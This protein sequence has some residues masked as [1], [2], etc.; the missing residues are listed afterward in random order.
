MRTELT[1]F[2]KE[3]EREILAFI[4]ESEVQKY[5]Q[6]KDLHDAVMAYIFRPAKRLRPAVLI[7]ACGCLGGAEELAIPAAAGIEL[8]HTWTLV[9]DDLIDNDDFRRG[10]PTVHRLMA[11]AGRTGLGLDESPAQDYGRHLAILAGD[12]Q[13]AWAINFFID[14]AG[15][16]KLDPW[17]VLKII[18]WLESYVIGNLLGGEA[19]DVQL[20]IAD[21]AGGLDFGEDD[22]IK[23]LWLKTGVLYEFA[24][25]AGAMIGKGATGFDDPEVEAVKRFTG[26]C[27]IAFQLQDDLLGVLGDEKIL[28][29]PVGS[30]IREGKK[31][32]I[33]Y[34]ALRNADED[35]RRTILRILGNKNAGADEIK[36]IIAL[37][38]E[39]NGID[40]TKQLAAA[41][42]N[43]ALPCLDPIPASKYKDL[44]LQWADYMIKRDL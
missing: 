38:R 13:H 39:L 22:I 16:K 31:T 8:F 44:L 23:M 20:G 34:E 2:L 18:S 29:K 6:P 36:K 15:K 40:H 1:V 14:L 5:I 10:A 11:E 25:M 19:L 28:G 35:Q 12:M 41:Y 17:V 7:M 24:G 37:F 21:I 30:D 43:K 32:T 27:G 33:L 42:I 3:K 4:K 9:H 26:Y